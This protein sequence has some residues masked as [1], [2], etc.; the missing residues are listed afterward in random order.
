[1][2]ARLGL[3][4]DVQSRLGA[5]RRPDDKKS[6]KNWAKEESLAEDSS[7]ATIDQVFAVFLQ[8]P[9]SSTVHCP[10]RMHILGYPI[11]ILKH[12][13][14]RSEKLTAQNLMK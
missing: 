1:M 7:Y 11:S 3:R 13:P 4:R 10:T 9:F 6:K 5:R 12:Y 2:K 8:S 14:F